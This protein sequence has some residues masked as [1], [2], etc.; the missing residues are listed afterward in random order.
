MSDNDILAPSIGLLRQKSAGEILDFMYFKEKYNKLKEIVRNPDFI[1]FFLNSSQYIC[2]TDK[3]LG[4]Y[5]T[6]NACPESCNNLIEYIENLIQQ[7]DS[8]VEKNILQYDDFCVL[9]Q[10]FNHKLPFEH[11]FLNKRKC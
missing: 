7:I 5:Y 10:I 8:R 9:N 11:S 2:K 6:C 3:C 1:K 4:P